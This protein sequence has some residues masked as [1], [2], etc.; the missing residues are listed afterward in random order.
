MTTP[1]C[2]SRAERR[3]AG[4]R[5]AVRHRDDYQFAATADTTFKQANFV[6]FFTIQSNILGVVALFTLVLVPHARR[7]PQRGQLCSGSGTGASASS[8]ADGP[9]LDRVSARNDNV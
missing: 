3:P 7:T 1:S 9:D 6:S 4:V 5:H 2:G 8:S